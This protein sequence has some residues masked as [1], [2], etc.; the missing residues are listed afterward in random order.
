MLYVRTIPGSH[1]EEEVEGTPH[2]IW[3]QHAQVHT[4]GEEEDGGEEDGGH[5][6]GGTEDRS[7]SVRGAEELGPGEQGVGRPGHGGGQK[8]LARPQKAPQR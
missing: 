6:E 4:A 7:K 3:G 2:L 1:Q 5:E 8:E